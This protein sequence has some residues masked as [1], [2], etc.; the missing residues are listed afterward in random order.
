[1]PEG[2]VS[3]APGPRTWGVDEAG[4]G[5]DD[6]GA[7]DILE[8]LPVG[9]IVFDVDQNLRYANPGHASLLGVDL[10]DCDSV[11]GW[12]RAGCRDAA[13]AEKV[14][15]DWR[16]HIWQKQVTRVFSLK[17]AADQLREI[18]FTPRLLGSDL[19]VV[20]RDVTESRQA[21]D[22]L[23]LMELKFGAVFEP[24]DRGIALIDATGRFLDVNPAFESLLGRTRNELRKMSLADCVAFSDIERLRAAEA[25]LTS[26]QGQVPDPTLLN[27]KEFRGDAAIRLRPREDEVF[28]AEVSLSV[29]RGSRG[30]ALYSVLHV[31]G[32][33]GEEAESVRQGRARNRALLEAIPD[34]IL[35][36]DSAGLVEDVMPANGGDWRGARAASD[37]VGRKISAVW[38]AFDAEAVRRVATAIDEGRM[39]SWRFTETSEDGGENRERHYAARVAPCEGNGAVVVVMDVTEEAEARECLV[40]QGLA[41]RHLEEAI[42]VTNLRGRI[43]DC[44]AA[45]ERI[46]GYSLGEIAGEGLARLYA[47]EEGADALNAEVSR[48]LTQEGRWEARRAFFRK[49]G[50]SGEADVVFLPVRESGA[51]RS[52]LGIHREVTDRSPDR[53]AAERMQHRWRNQLQS[54]HGLLSLELQDR[55]KLESALLA[56]VQGRLKAISRLHEMA[57]SIESPVALAPY[58]RGLAADLRRMTAGDVEDPGSYPLLEVG[59]GESGEVRVDFEVATTFGLLLVEVALVL[60]GVR[61]GRSDDARLELDLFEGHP[62]M[63]ASLPSEAMAGFSLPVMRALVEQL[64]GSLNVSHRDERAEWI[65]RFP[66]AR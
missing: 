27:R 7:F 59:D 16:E 54:V 35:V 1:M 8:S 26:Q 39:K 11:E 48:A 64:R 61:G 32:A 37:W 57:E 49:D 33:P 51:P 22:A 58:A 50:S 52:L 46:F 23:R 63:R 10:G 45:A 19:L 47:P 34:L 3:A 43:V 18:E 66:A 14:I 29:V 13:Y 42:I 55:G 31:L 60:F 25:R 62:R 41:F 30:R 6:P 53:D 17:N 15:V 28:P 2:P 9:V 36:L 40:R 44:N 38:P 21:E 65:L 12:L 20:L 56:K 5:A 4:V 24:A